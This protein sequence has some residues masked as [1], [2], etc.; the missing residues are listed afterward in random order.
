MSEVIFDCTNPKHL[1]KGV[2]FAEVDNGEVKKEMNSPFPTPKDYVAGVMAIIHV[3][4]NGIWHLT[5]RIKF[6]SGNK[7]VIRLQENPP[8]N[9]TKLLQKFYKIPLVNKI[10]TPNP[11]GDSDGIL[12][13]IKDLDMIESIQIEET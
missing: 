10:W 5:A 2:L 8:C 11:S 13:I 6:P 9:E 7:Q 3:D 4:E 1:Y 12:N